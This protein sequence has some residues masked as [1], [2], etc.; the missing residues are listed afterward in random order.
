MISEYV[1]NKNVDYAILKKC[2][3]NKS[4]GYGMYKKMEEDRTNQVELLQYVC[5]EAAEFIERRKTDTVY[6][7]FSEKEL[8][9]I[10]N[11]GLG[12]KGALEAFKKDYAPYIVL[13]S[14]P[15]FFGYVVGGVTPAALAGDWLTSLYD[16]NAFGTPGSVDRQIEIEAVNGIKDLLGIH[17]DMIGS[18]TSGA[19]M[20]TTAALAVAREWAAKE[21]GKTADDG[22]YGLERPVLL[23]GTAH[24]SIYKGLSILGLGRNSITAVGCIDNREAVD[25]VKL[26]KA[27]EENKGKACIVIANMGTANSGDVDD[28]KAIAALKEKFNFFLHIDGAIGIVAAASPKYKHMFEGLEA[29]DSL[30]VD[31]HKWLNVPYDCAISMIRKEYKEYQYRTY[32]QAASVTGPVTETTEYTSLG[33]EGSRRFRALSVW[34]SL[35][36]YG[37]EG[38]AEMVERDCAMARR[39]AGLLSDSGYLKV[40]GAVLLNGFAFSLNKD[41]T[42]DEEIADLMRAIKEDGAGFLN[43]A[44]LCGNPVLRCSLSNWGT[45]EDDV[46][47]VAASVIKCAKAILN[48]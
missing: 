6:P 44:K 32:A 45:E 42:T 46:D 28:L 24:P 11:E 14:G 16:Q 25:L 10:S 43:N 7:F 13:D 37:K 9:S 26:E 20:A 30:T 5:Q 29:A 27:L 12:A 34:L 47:A 3:F 17:K 39:F 41:H 33:N 21:Q 19:T 40:H 48:R 31:C 18:F 22:V 1:L 23:S 8:A 15:R 2:L 38:Y 36:A 4:G 35:M